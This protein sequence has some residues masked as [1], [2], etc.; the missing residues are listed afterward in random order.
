M[1]N[2]C[3]II[4]RRTSKEHDWN[5]KY[6]AP[7]YPYIHIWGILAGAVL[8]SF[9]GTKAFI[10]G[11]AAVLSGATTY[12][13]YGKKHAIYQRTPVQS[14]R[15]QFK[16]TTVAEHERRLAAFHAA[17]LGGKNHLTLREFQSALKAL[18]FE[19]SVDESRCIFHNADMDENGVIDIDEFFLAFESDESEE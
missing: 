15:E 18:G 2:T 12:Y 14:F 10:G 9:I 19:Y 13:L 11:G 17:D 6:K 16:F 7:L 1:I 5:P 4:L 8:I 3:V